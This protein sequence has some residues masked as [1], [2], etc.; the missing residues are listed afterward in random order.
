MQSAEAG[1]AKRSSRLCRKT[2]R[3]S[4]LYYRNGYTTILKYSQ[5]CGG[6]GG[7]A[8]RRSGFVGRCEGAARSATSRAT[9]WFD[10]T[11]RDMYAS[12][13]C[14]DSSR[15]GSSQSGLC[16]L[17]ASSPPDVTPGDCES[18]EARPLSGPW[19][20]LGVGCVLL[21]VSV[22]LGSVDSL[23]DHAYHR[24]TTAQRRQ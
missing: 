5:L 24:W 10:D 19:R 2:V 16:R 4:S 22:I 7:V 1:S 15:E 14:A 23:L 3:G 21:Q 6:G 18:D 12:N 13:V 20:G 9:C 11:G 8:I 17:S